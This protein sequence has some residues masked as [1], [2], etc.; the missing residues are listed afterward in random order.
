MLL[1]EAVAA[2]FGGYR[3]L[4]EENETM[5]QLGREMNRPDWIAVGSAY[6]QQQLSTELAS[7]EATAARFSSPG[8]KLW[9]I[10]DPA[11]KIC[12]SIG[13]IWCD[14]ADDTVELVRLYVDVS[15]RRRGLGLTLFGEL[16]AHAQTLGARQI[17][18][19]TPTE[20]VPGNAFYRRLGFSQV[21]SFTV[22][23]FA[24]PLEIAELRLDLD[25]KRR[26]AA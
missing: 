21:R 17:S 4:F 22:R 23:E 10:L 13:A 15:C 5:V 1:R 3:R 6:V 26:A 8:S 19:T 9:L 14:S 25:E 18:L 7:W 12:G 2:D 16:A 11:G 20:N 24:A